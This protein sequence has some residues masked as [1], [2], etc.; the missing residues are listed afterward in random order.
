MSPFQK[1]SP[2]PR[3]RGEVEDDLGI[4]AGL[5]ARR[6]DRP[7]ATGPAIAPPALI[8]KPIFSASRSKA[9]ATGSTTSASSAVGF[10]NRSAWT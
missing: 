5:A 9:E 3:R 10:M 7:G 6:D 1:C 4:R 8:S 2:R